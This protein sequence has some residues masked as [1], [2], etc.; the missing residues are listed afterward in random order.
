MKASLL[1]PEK[2]MARKKILTEIQRNGNFHYNI[3]VIEKGEGELVVVRRPTE[4][5]RAT[6]FCLASIV[7][8]SM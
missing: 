5:K 6:N 3:K 4:M 1:T 7:A 8:D 2:S